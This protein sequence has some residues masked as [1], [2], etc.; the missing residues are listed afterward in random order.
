MLPEV[1]VSVFAGRRYKTSKATK[2]YAKQTISG[3]NNS[4][5][6][7]RQKI[8]CSSK[9]R[10]PSQ[11]TD[12]KKS[13]KKK[14]KELN[15]KVG[16]LCPMSGRWLAACTWAQRPPFVDSFSWVTRVLLLRV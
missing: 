10:G 9:F 14:N 3:Q 1:Y 6:K 7:A 15:K 11:Q 4:V 16:P 5:S 2:K 13:L 8:Y 12:I